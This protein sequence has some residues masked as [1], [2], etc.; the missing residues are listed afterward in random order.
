MN[1]IVAAVGE[2]AEVS[3]KSFGVEEMV[4][5]LRVLHE[6]FDGATP[7]IRLGAKITQALAR[8]CGEHELRHGGSK[9]RG[10]Y[11]VDPQMSYGAPR[12]YRLRHEQHA[13]HHACNHYGHS[14]DHDASLPELQLRIIM[15]T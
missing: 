11:L 14:L 7:A 2:V 15:A 3:G 12:A 1:E 5:L 4:R 13:D 8:S 9:L 10:G 6:F